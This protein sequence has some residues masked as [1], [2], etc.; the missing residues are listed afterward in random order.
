ME[1]NEYPCDNCPFVTDNC[2]C[3]KLYEWDEMNSTLHL[4]DKKKEIEDYSFLY[5]FINI[6]TKKRPIIFIP[7][8]NPIFKVLIDLEIIYSQFL[9]GLPQILL[10]FQI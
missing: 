3:S 1:N 9:V 2:V 8:R 10:L 5:F 4:K 7:Y 6:L